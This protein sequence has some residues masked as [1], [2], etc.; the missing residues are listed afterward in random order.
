MLYNELSQ[1][2]RFQCAYI[3][4]SVKTWFKKNLSVLE[5]EEWNY[6][7]SIYCIMLYQR[8][9]D[10]TTSTVF[11]VLCYIRVGGMELPRQYLLYYVISERN[12]TTFTVFTVLCY[13]I[14]GGIELPLQYVLYYVIQ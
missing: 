7:Y 1:K 3:T 10:G 2:T 11:T 6:L 13:I 5:R 14:E 12:G 8:G 4:Y 9:R